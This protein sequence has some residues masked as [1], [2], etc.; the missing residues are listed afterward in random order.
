MAKLNNLRAQQSCAVADIAM[1]PRVM[2]PPFLEINQ[3]MQHHS[4]TRKNSE[5]QWQTQGGIQGCKGNPF[6]AASLVHLVDAAVAH[7]LVNTARIAKYVAEGGPPLC[8]VFQL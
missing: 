2:E 4:R 1:V 6:S 7:C 3:L 8:W 5:F